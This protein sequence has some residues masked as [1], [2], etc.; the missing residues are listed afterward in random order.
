MDLERVLLGEDW[1]LGWDGWVFRIYI[2][3]YIL[4]RVL[5]EKR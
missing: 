5:L 2:R 1:A 4:S 3:M